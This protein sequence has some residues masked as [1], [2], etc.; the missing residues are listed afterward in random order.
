[1]R[2]SNLTYFIIPLSPVPASLS[3][4]A[5]KILWPKALKHFRA[6]SWKSKSAVKI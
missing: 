3:A 1:M 4:D 5:V 6:I 2:S